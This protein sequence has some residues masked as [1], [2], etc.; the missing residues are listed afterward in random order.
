MKG[1]Y[2]H[3]VLYYVYYDCYYSAQCYMAD[4]GDLSETE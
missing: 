3:I 1:Y 4:K 2:A